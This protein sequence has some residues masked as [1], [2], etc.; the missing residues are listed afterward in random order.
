MSEAAI[1]KHIGFILDGNRRWAQ[2]NGLPKLV[3]HKKGY[4]NLKT[5]AEACFEK[6]IEVVSAFIFSTENWSRE[7]DEVDYL[8]DLAL[9][10]FKR[11]LK[12]LM[13]KNFRLVVS[14]SR[15][16][17]S[18]KL[19]EAIEDAQRKTS[20]NSG[21]TIN[22]CFNYGGQTEISDAFKKLL[23]SGVNS[24]SVT[25]EMI[26][27][28][29]YHPELPPVDFIVRTSGEKR[30]SNFLLWDAAYAELEFVEVHW[31]AFSEKDL[32]KVL[33]EYSART[34]RFGQ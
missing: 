5:I 32:Q 8:M 34:R 13:E 10:L 19:V 27:A 24:S 20:G 2:E 17:L 7:K 33:A 28:N 4:D 16:K 30:I 1:P 31:P 6:G 9:K 23:E 15:E 25:P 22:I 14:G 3:G 11:D 29:L 26:R 12:E 18:P 21:G